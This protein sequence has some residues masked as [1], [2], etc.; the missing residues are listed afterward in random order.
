MKNT[1][2][3][4]RKPIIDNCSL[5]EIISR[6]LQGESISSLAAEFG[7]SR[8]ALYKR[9]RSSTESEKNIC[10]DYYSGDKK[11]TRIEVDFAHEK[12]HVLNYAIKISERAFGIN[13][14]PSWE[15]FED[16]LWQKL[17]LSAGL[18]GDSSLKQFWVNETAKDYFS[19]EDI[20]D[21]EN[22]GL[23]S[24]DCF[25][26][27][28][29][30]S[31]KKNDLITGR[32]DTDGYQMKAL[33]KDRRW[34]VKSQAVIGGELMDDW[35]VELIASDF[36]KQLSIPCIEQRR[37]EISYAGKRYDA[38]YSQNFELDG[39]SF[40]SFERLLERQGLSSNDEEFIKLNA[41]EK[42][43]WCAKKL[44]V[45]GNLPYESAEKYMLDM[46]LI[47]CLI[48]NVDRHTKNFGLFFNAESSRYEIPLIFDNGMGLFE[49]DR[50]KNSYMCFED[51]M[52]NVYVSP[53]GEDPF[54]MIKMLD[55][56]YDLISKYPKLST[57]TAHSEWMSTFAKKYLERMMSI[58]QK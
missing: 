50:Y 21:C 22:T 6:S 49:H 33:S 15:D 10:I 46:A 17:L 1:R 3:A 39:Y 8:Q 7:V 20:V 48:G 16:F 2:N 54:D 32:T 29:V 37:C 51:A 24:D 40:I 12:I 41:I 18:S 53:Y 5:D 19:L 34:F 52:R 13:S 47:D 27:T 4:G 26:D 44:S 45:G 28:P 25:I 35:A 36:C 14:N 38:V 23:K 9:I 57:L 30:F 55:T 42:L 43:K 56:E 31:F 11:A 58:W